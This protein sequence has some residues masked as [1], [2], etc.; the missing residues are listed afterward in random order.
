MPSPIERAQEYLIRKSYPSYNKNTCGR[1]ASKVADAWDFAFGK[2]VKRF[3]HAKDCG[4][5]YEDLGFKKVFSYPEQSK[6]DYKPELGDV[7][8]IQP[9]K[10]LKEG[11]EI[12]SHPSGHVCVRCTWKDVA[13]DKKT[14]K[15]IEITRLGWISDF[16]QSTGGSKL[17]LADMYGGPI[18]DKNPAF[19]IYRLV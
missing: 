4:A 17:P 3:T 10:I 11:K 9:V 1:C 8:I 14:K 12:I 7:A 6:E 13:E 15:I 18:R 2:K 16:K 5:T 19:A